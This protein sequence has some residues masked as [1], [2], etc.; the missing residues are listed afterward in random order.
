MAEPI[1]LKPGSCD[2]NQSIKLSTKTGKFIP[3]EKR[4]ELTAEVARAKMN[5]HRDFAQRIGAV[6]RSISG[7][8]NCVGMVFAARR[9][10]IDPEY[11]PMILEEDNYRKLDKSDEIARD[12]V[13][14]YYKWHEGVIHVGRIAGKEVKGDGNI[15]WQVLSKWGEDGEYFHPIT[16]VPLL[17][18][19]D[20][21]EIWTDRKEHA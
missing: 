20:R 6:F 12:D 21:W 17:L 8:Y 4:D 10:C 1:I 16:E 13:V 11:V 7:V 9:V 19:F 5:A 18:K 14:V 2:D 15:E 3:N